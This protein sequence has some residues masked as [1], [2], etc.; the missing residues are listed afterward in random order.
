MAEQI[1]YKRH[2]AMFRNAPIL[3][4]LC[5]LLVLVYGVGLLILA[6]WFLSVWGTT[7]TVS[8]ERVTL[9][10]GILSKHTNEVMIRDIRNVQISQGI[11]QRLFGVGSI[12]VGSA[13]HG[14]VEIEAA[15]IPFPQRVKQIIDERRRNPHPG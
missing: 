4:V 6:V 10:K 3:F 1:L 12:A 8:D 7:L 14:G 11:F 9:R 2:P 5:C 13:G 15:G